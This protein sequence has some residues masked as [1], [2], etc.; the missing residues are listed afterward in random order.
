M[1]FCL[2]A[3]IVSIHDVSPHTWA[4]C[5]A[6]LADL[7][8]AGVSRTSLLVIPDHHRRGH[9]L[10][11]AGFCEWLKEQ[12]QAGHEI[13]AHGYFHQRERREGESAREKMIT[14][15]YTADEGE[16]FDLGEDEA[17]EKLQRALANFAQIDL[18][19]TGFIAPAWLL[20]A[21][22][23]TAARKAGFRY[24]TLL[25]EIRDL[26]TGE[27]HLSQSLVWSTRSGWRRIVSLGWNSFLR[28]RL[29][30]NPVIRLG[31]HP[32]D[33]EHP[34]L[35]RQILRFVRELRTERTVETYAEWVSDRCAAK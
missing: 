35:R 8:V 13:V 11:D 33:W 25:R 6:I 20:S 1:S 12:A 14:R 18:H 31:I 17:A 9:F 22:A 30:A 24:T 23:E 21:A 10:D 2:P 28:W 29:R 26:T 7:R 34:A 5:R 16:F 4:V 27:T 19:P 3:L 32:P 15:V